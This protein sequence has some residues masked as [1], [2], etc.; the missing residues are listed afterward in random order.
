MQRLSGIHL[1]VAVLLVLAGVSGAYSAEAPSPPTVSVEADGKVSAKPDMATL[2]L[3]VETQA[4]SAAAAS[5]DNA[6]RTQTLLAA[7]KPALGP[8]DQLR[9]LSFRLQPVRVP[10]DKTHPLEI[11]G[12]QAVHRL[13]VKVKDLDR[14]GRV[15]DTA[16]TKGASQINGPYWGHSHLEELQRQAAVDALGRARRL[17]EALAQASGLKIQGLEKI[18]TGVR[19]LPARAA[20]EVYLAAKAGAAPPME[21][22]EEEIKAHIQAVFRL[23]P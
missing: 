4:A 7:L 3:E 21:V 5:K 1:A 23:T 18:S 6:G 11:K 19:L 10:R 16:L 12:Y 14:L 15:L 9:T 13:E 8:E 22:G 17:A 20:G 2:T